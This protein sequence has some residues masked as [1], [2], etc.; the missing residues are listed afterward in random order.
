MSRT[1]DAHLVFTIDLRPFKRACEQVAAALGRFAEVFTPEGRLRRD[2][3]DIG[4]MGRDARAWPDQWQSTICAGLLCS[5]TPCPSDANGLG[6]T[7]S[8][9]EETP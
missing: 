5:I 8:C 9:H 7:H 2:R 3:R 6:C 1:K 4:G